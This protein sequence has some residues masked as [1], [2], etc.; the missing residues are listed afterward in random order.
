MILGVDVGASGCLVIL[1]AMGGYEGHLH[2]PTIKVGTKTR[3]NGAAI[4]QWLESERL[5]IGLNR[6]THAYIE[7]TGAMPAQGGSSM[8]S[9]GHAT[10]LVE[11]VIVGAG[12][13]ITLV[14]PQAWK[15]HNKLIGSEKDAARSRAVQLYPQ[16][17]DLNLKG[18][19]QAL[20]DA[21]L[22]GRYGL[23]I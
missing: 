10:G 11:G 7:L 4:A 18:K 22:I 19:G 3:V 23:G 9:F 2:M 17:A 20:G 14:T 6:F 12:I 21:I 15:K 16:V 5:R 1:N 13:P 8:F